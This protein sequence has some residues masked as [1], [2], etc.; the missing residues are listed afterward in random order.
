LRAAGLR[1]LA[2]CALLTLFAACAEKAEAPSEPAIELR[3]AAFGDLV[4]W[5]EDDPTAALQ[6][7]RTSCVV[8]GR[9]V[10]TDAMGRESW[11]GKAGDWQPL[12]VEAGSVALEPTAARAFFEAG[13]VPVLVTDRGKAEGLFTGYYEPLLMGSRTPGGRFTVPLHKRPSDLVNVDLGA[14]DTALEGKRI[15]GRVDG[16]RLLPY[17]DRAAIDAGALAGRGNEL[18]WVDDPI[19]KF[20]LQIQ[21]SGLVELGEGQRVR[22]GYAD[23][24]G[25][26]YRAIG[27][28]L[29][30]MGV[31][32]R[33]EVS[34]QTIRDWLRAH[35]DQAARIMEKNPSYVFFREQGDANKTT[36]PIGA[37]NVPLTAERSI[38]V[39]R[40]FMPLG[41]PIWLETTAPF[42]GGDR[43]LHRL[44]VAQDTGGA[45]KG[46]VR[47]D[48]FWGTGPVAEHVA[49][50]MKSPGRWLVLLPR[51]LAPTS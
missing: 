11:A 41:A 35:P 16:G 24:N 13:F 27:R 43:P 10:A 20:F 51:A 1:A 33:E 49:G 8:I 40:R 34:L 23:Q 48:V 9:R 32:T 2:A 5:A 36:G 22:I 30:E 42:P 15:A 46:P 19:G 37:Q 18:L 44:V 12:C 29:V 25:R 26:S 47:G 17:P 45:I 50:H 31:L 14:F 38:A 39:D 6:A 21:G 3:P 7:F 4:G 28:D